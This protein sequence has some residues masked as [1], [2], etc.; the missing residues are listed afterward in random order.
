MD[1]PD[2]YGEEFHRLPFSTAVEQDL[3][4]DYKVIVLAMSEQDT[5]AALQTYRSSGGGEI[6]IND[7]TKIVGCWRALQKPRK[8]VA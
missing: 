1:D 8:K 6:N 3:L 4:S 2:T 7:A 5:D